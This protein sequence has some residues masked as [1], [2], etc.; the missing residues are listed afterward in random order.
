[1]RN[2]KDQMALLS[3]KKGNFIFY[4]GLSDITNM[5]RFWNGKWFTFI[6]SLHVTS[7]CD[8]V[9]ETRIRLNSGFFLEKAFEFIYLQTI[10]V[11]DFVLLT[12]NPVPV[13]GVRMVGGL[14]VRLQEVLALTAARDNLRSR[15]VQPRKV[16]IS[17]LKR[18]VD[19]LRRLSKKVSVQISNLWVVRW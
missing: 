10:P 9:Y 14:D 6:L 11:R 8:S 7:C 18:A 19:V 16:S 17:Q 4:S 5:L 1:M 15:L 3:W 13:P 12:T 2:M